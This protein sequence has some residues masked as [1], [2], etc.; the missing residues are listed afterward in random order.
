M[1]SV[2]FHNADPIHAYGHFFNR[3]IGASDEVEAQGAGK[4]FDRKFFEMDTA[5]FK[6]DVVAIDHFVGVMAAESQWSR[7]IQARQRLIS[8]SL[9]KELKKRCRS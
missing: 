8:I 9:G 4:V 6:I 7:G 5:A 3:I 2:L 1:F